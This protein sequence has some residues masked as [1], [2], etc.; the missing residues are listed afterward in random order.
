MLR[1][2]PPAVIYLH[3]CFYQRTFFCSF[4]AKGERC[5]G[6]TWQHVSCFPSL[7]QLI[8][9]C[10]D[11]LSI[12]YAAE[13]LL[14]LAGG[15]E[16]ERHGRKGTAWARRA[17]AQV[18]AEE[19]FFFYSR[20]PSELGG[21]CFA[22]CVLWCLCV[23][24]VHVGIRSYTCTRRCQYIRMLASSETFTIM[25]LHHAWA[26]FASFFASRGLNL[27]PH[28]RTCGCASRRHQQHA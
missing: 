10:V 27:F 22:D 15:G 11:I 23:V 14:S 4:G 1:A 19:C 26:P 20:V 3:Y 8:L 6:A 17:R 28:W 18:V 13:R 21:A 5:Y 25:H 2:A 12:V 7:Q 24:S 9:Y 16:R